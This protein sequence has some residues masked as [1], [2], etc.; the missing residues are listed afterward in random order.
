MKVKDVLFDAAWAFQ[1]A[2]VAVECAVGR[3]Q[4]ARLSD[5][6]ERHRQI[7]LFGENVEAI[8]AAVLAEAV[9]D[10]EMI[11]GHE[12]KV[13]VIRIGRD[14]HSQF[15]EVGQAFGGQCVLADNGERG[16]QYRDQYANDSDDHEK[17]DKCEAL[18]RWACGRA[19]ACGTKDRRKESW[20]H[21]KP[22]APSR[23][24]PQPSINNNAPEDVLLGIAGIC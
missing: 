7:S 17:F 9:F 1:N 20:M 12:A 16:N 23:F 22:K 24:K 6:S 19:A 18:A 2:V 15:L 21:S 13:V 3:K 14:G 5:M 4:I 11:A 10:A 8:A